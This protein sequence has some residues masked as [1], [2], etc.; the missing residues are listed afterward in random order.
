VVMLISSNPTFAS[1]D[2]F[3]FYR[4]RMT[5]LAISE[6]YF[7]R[8]LFCPP[9]LHLFVDPG[10]LFT[11]RV[12]EVLLNEAYWFMKRVSFSYSASMRFATNRS[13]TTISNDNYL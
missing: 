5:Y 4:A 1:E 2:D 11:C 12:M 8:Y 10:N 7:W 9:R 6:L 13:I 3:L